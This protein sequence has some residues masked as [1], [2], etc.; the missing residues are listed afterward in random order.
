MSIW[1]PDGWSGPR[2]EEPSV[3]YA[4][5]LGLD[6]I[7][8]ELL[9]ERTTGGNHFGS[10]TSEMR[11]DVNAR[12]GQYGTPLCAASA[13]GNEA[14]VRLLLEKGADINAQA[15]YMGEPVNALIVAVSSGHERVI[16]LLL[17]KGADI[18]AHAG[19]GGTALTAA[20]SSGHDE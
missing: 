18:D 4:S 15:G 13:F 3:Y 19:I 6:S 14:A 7:L 12:G 17:E 10:D 5:L 1:D 16:R 20:A 2:S 9:Q 11:L 8:S